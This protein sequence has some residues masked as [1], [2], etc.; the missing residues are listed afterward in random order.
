MEEETERFTI[1]ITDGGLVITGGKGL[2]LEFT[3]GEALMLLGILTE[4]EQRLRNMAQEA[5]P[6]PIKIQV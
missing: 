5:S 2:S 4:E 3:A 6:A 1:E